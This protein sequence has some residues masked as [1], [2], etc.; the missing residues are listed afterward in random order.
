[1]KCT[2]LFF[3]VAASLFAADLLSRRGL[4]EGRWAHP[5]TAGENRNVN[6]VQTPALSRRSASV[7]VAHDTLREREAPYRVEAGRALILALPDALAG[8]SVAAYAAVRAP[9]LSM[10]EGRSF[11]WRTRPQEAGTHRVLLE[12]AF[13]DA[14]PDTLALEVIVE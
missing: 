3:V 5:P 1:M 6:A 14:P 12:A 11:V 9:A 2:A 8:R 7:S 10:V 4:P 13:S